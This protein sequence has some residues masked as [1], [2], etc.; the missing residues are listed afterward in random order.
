MTSKRPLSH[1]RNRFLRILVVMGILTIG[2]VG[3]GD[4]PTEPDFNPDFMVG[5]WLAESLVQ[6]SV[7]DPQVFTDLVADLGAVFT[8]SVQPSGRYM[9]ILTGFGQS[10]SESGRLTIDDAFVI[11][12]PE[13]PP[14]R[15]GRPCG[16]AWAT[17][18]S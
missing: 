2:A 8:L 5:D 17:P 18:S 7:A 13:V 12:M 15:H 6:T 4:G 10:T 3:C 16:S 14:A 11:L 1:T 9:A